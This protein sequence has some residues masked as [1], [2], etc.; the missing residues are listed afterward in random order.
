M[1]GYSI[2]DCKVREGTI[3]KNIALL[4]KEDLEEKSKGKMQR[5]TKYFGIIYR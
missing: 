5:I 4:S 3:V 2:Y 1:V